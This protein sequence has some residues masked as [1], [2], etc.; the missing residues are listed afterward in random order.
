MDAITHSQHGTIFTGSAVHIMRAATV[1]SAIRM[2]IHSGMLITR[3]M[4]ISKLMR[5]AS[6]ITDKKFKARDY[7]GA[8]AALDQW[9]TEAK[10]KVLHIQE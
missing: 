7:A 5:A 9:I 1:R 4:T 8:M 10:V 6:D 3:G 2:Y